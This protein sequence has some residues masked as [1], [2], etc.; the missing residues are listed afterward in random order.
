MTPPSPWLPSG[1]PLL[2]TLRRGR[3]FGIKDQFEVGGV[4][5]IDKLFYFFN[6]VGKEVGEE[7][8]GNARDLVKTK[9][10]W[11]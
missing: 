9:A 5:P 8:E 10:A 7:S 11:R 3:P 6:A 1:V 2:D 4:A